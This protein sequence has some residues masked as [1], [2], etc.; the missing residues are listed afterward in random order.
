M[1][2][3][4]SCRSIFFLNPGIRWFMVKTNKQAD[5]KV[6]SWLL[7]EKD[8]AYFY[9][10]ELELWIW[11]LLFISRVSLLGLRNLSNA[12]LWHFP[13]STAVILTDANIECNDLP[14]DQIKLLQISFRQHLLL[15]SIIFRK[16]WLGM[17]FTNSELYL[18]AESITSCTLTRVFTRAP[19]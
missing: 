10:R 19:P 15:W 4:D 12:A 17:D 13:S 8:V 14:A 3:E 6:V 9:G 16:A 7:R 11:T 5:C 2:I 18:Y 1:F